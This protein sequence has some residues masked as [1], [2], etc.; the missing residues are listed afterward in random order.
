M[1]M[2]DLFSTLRVEFI[3][4]IQP[5]L[6]E[7]ERYSEDE[8]FYR[9]C[10]ELRSDVKALTEYIGSFKERELQDKGIIIPTKKMAPV[11]LLY[12]SFFTPHNERN[13]FLRKHSRYTPV[14]E[15]SHDF[16]EIFFVFSGTCVNMIAGERFMLPEGSLC[17][18]APHINH[19][20][21]VFDNSIIINILIRKASFD[22]IFFNL[23]TTDDF[24]SSFF[25][26]NIYQENPARY[27]IFD[28]AGDIELTETILL[29]LVEQ[30]RGDAYSERLMDNL[31]S[32][33]FTL[34]IRKYTKNKKILKTAGGG[35]EK[36]GYIAY[37]NEHFRTITLS[38]L[39][40]HFS[41]SVSHCSRLIKSLTGKNFT[42]LVRDIRLYHA[43]A[44][45]VSSDMNIRDISYSLGYENQE[46]F[47]RSFKKAFGVSPNKY[48][49]QFITPS[50]AGPGRHFLPG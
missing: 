29:M 30:A 4:K 15:H 25:I 3:Q 40:R 24:L 39:A 37:I 14:F 6:S 47:F 9:R 2:T 31:V 41:V 34:L 42:A 35:T 20:I 1:T 28:M 50:S 43:K 49:E 26:G 33:F 19:T 11:K 27:I 12:S 36:S 13:V 5:I 44:L 32:M 22:E 21:E 7:L 23:L 10:Y 18:I 16:F 38:K 17:F 45:L 46:T 48:R 8:L